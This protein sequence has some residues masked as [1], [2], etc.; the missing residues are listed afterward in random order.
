M[1][2]NVDLTEN[3]IFKEKN[4]ASSNFHRDFKINSIFLLRGVSRKSLSNKIKKCIADIPYCIDND[5]EHYQNGGIIQGDKYRRNYYSTIQEESYCER[6]GRTKKYFW[7]DFNNGL[8]PKC[9]KE[10]D[11]KRS[12]YA[13]FK[14]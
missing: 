6:C 3:E 10:L 2:R 7:E 14:N 1:K 5:I 4:I 8:C 9:S 12:S 11:K 13:R